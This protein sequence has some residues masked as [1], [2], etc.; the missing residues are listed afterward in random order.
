MLLHMLLLTP[1]WKEQLRNWSNGSFSIGSEQEP[2]TRD[3]GSSVSTLNRKKQTHYRTIS[4][5]ASWGYTSGNDCW[6]NNNPIWFRWNK[7]A[8][9]NSCNYDRWLHYGGTYIRC[10]KRLGELTPQLKYGACNDHHISNATKHGCKSFDSDTHELKH[11][12]EIAKSKG[13]NPKAL[14]QFRE[15]R[16]WSYVTS[17]ILILHNWDTIVEYYSL[18]SKPTPWQEKL[19]ILLMYI[20]FLSLFQLEFI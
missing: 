6:I 11:E 19:K 2:R 14:K 20:K 12:Y 4:V 10:K 18:V 17:I 13:R 7:L 16:F 15:T 8:T 1:I 5:E 9:K 3:Y